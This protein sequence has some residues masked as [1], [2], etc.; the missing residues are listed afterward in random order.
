MSTSTSTSTQSVKINYKPLIVKR[1]KQYEKIL[2]ILVLA[3]SLLDNQRDFISNRDVVNDI[4]KITPLY[5][6]TEEI[7]KIDIILKIINVTDI[8]NDDNP[9]LSYKKLSTFDINK[10]ENIYDNYSKE[11]KT[12]K[13]NFFRTG[14]IVEFGG[15][16]YFKMKYAE[17]LNE[18]L[19][20]E[21]KQERFNL[22]GYSIDD[23][24]DDEP[25]YTE[26]DFVD[27]YYV[28]WHKINEDIWFENE[29]MRIKVLKTQ[30]GPFNNFD[31]NIRSH[32]SDKSYLF[33]QLL[34]DILG[35]LHDSEIWKNLKPFLEDYYVNFS[36]NKINV[37][38][39]LGEDPIIIYDP[40]NGDI[41]KALTKDKLEL[42]NQSFRPDGK[43]LY[44]MWPI[45]L[46]QTS[47]LPKIIDNWRYISN[48]L[49]LEIGNGTLRYVSL[50]DS[51]KV[52][53]H[54]PN[55]IYIPRLRVSGLKSNLRGHE[56]SIV[57]EL[58]DINVKFSVETLN[59]PKDDPILIRYNA[60]MAKLEN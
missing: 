2:K 49:Y 6:D 39:Q 25:E 44:D 36:N 46:G 24:P 20:K 30:L 43:F 48:N 10:L 14:K 42:F 37:Y 23:E 21:Y 51:Q 38:K 12:L 45:I 17:E 3:K 31:A 13:Y 40:E 29:E 11:V 32:G 15:K 54:F 35:Q 26:S 18:F 19:V 16:Y 57:D 47:E 59:L 7:N 58:V 56:Y 27:P 4:V 34:Q 28:A 41:E 55:Y 1:I 8:Y 52:W 53:E 33:I 5:L 22:I 9:E 50:K 60:E